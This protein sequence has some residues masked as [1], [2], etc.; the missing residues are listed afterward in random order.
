MPVSSEGIEKLKMCH[1]KCWEIFQR[2]KKNLPV[3]EV[4]KLPFP[5]LRKYQQRLVGNKGYKFLMAGG[6]VILQVKGLTLVVRHNARA[7]ISVEQDT[8]WK[9]KVS[10]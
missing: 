4:I 2:T 1:K 3:K 9:S 10:V 7:Q 6:C 8:T 5:L